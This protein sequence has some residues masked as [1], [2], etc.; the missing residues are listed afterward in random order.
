M[1]YLL[2]AS[3]FLLIFFPLRF[4]N[5]LIIKLFM[6]NKEISHSACA[7]YQ[8]YPAQEYVKQ[9]STQLTFNLESAI[10]I[11]INL[12]KI[13]YYYNIYKLPRLI[14][15]SAISL[16]SSYSK[17]RLSEVGETNLASIPRTLR[18]VIKKHLNN[19]A[20]Q[21]Y[22]EI[23]MDEIH[24]YRMSKRRDSSNSSNLSAMNF[25]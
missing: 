11:V 12:E 14:A 22:L 8:C 9:F 21:P 15:I 10:R 17:K 2:L 3:N 25:K 5:V 19:K 13:C 1:I 7:K 18:E 20:I 24:K 4:I 16:V 6:N 23:I